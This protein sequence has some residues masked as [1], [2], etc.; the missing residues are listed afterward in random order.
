MPAVTATPHTAAHRRGAS[1]LR[2]ML[3]ARLGGPT[4]RVGRT[5]RV[6]R[7]MLCASP[8]RQPCGCVSPAAEQHTAAPQ[9]SLTVRD[10]MNRSAVLSGWLC[11]YAYTRIVAGIVDMPD[12]IDYPMKME[13]TASLSCTHLEGSFGTRARRPVVDRRLPS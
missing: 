9:T 12:P 7:V 11:R 3:C 13:A 6:L 2:V 4:R 10:A 8:E 5:L 1:V